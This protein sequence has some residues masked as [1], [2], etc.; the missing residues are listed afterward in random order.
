MAEHQ[1]QRGNSH[2]KHDQSFLH[3]TGN[4]GHPMTR[5]NYGQVYGMHHSQAAANMLA[6]GIQGMSMQD[7][8][9]PQGKGPLLTTSGPHYAGLAINAGFPAALWGANSHLMYPGGQAYPNS[10]HQ[11]SPGL[12]TPVSSQYLQHGYGQPHDNSPISQTWTPSHTTGEVPTLIT[13]RRDSVSSNENDAPGTPSYSTYPY[14][15][16]VTIINRSPNGIYTHSTP[17]PSQVMSQY[18]MPSIKTPEARSIS[19]ELH[20]LVSKE[21][22]IPPA[23]PAP[24]S[25]L[26]PL[27]RALENLRGETNVYIRGLHPDTTDDMLETWG[28]RFGDIRSS[29]SIIDHATGLCK[30]FGFVKYHNYEDAGNCIRGFHYLGYEVSFARESFYS[31][32]KTFADDDNTNLYVSNLPKAMN[33]HELASLFAPHKVCSARILR[34]KNGVGRGVGFARFE[35]RKTCTAVVTEFNNKAVKVGGDEYIINIR[36]A[37]SPEQKTLKQQVSSARAFRSQEY[38]AA[39]QQLSSLNEF[40]AALSPQSNPSATR[41]WSHSAMR[42]PLAPLPLN[43][44]IQSPT[45]KVQA[46]AMSDSKPCIA[47]SPDSPTSSE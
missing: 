27:D 18:G 36:Y 30:G 46:G 38:M 25:P 16:G 34:D 17:S 26:K 33:E 10:S 44:N 2:G 22:S 32:L 7:G 47:R 23:I 19:T 37:D 40:E 20:A 12:Y 43:N 35:D 9:Y 6:Q 31:K 13:P 11:H 45:S 39:T 24:S 21:P 41:S 4:Y 15:A 29:K 3:R 14:Q 28:R 1:G 8:G 5:G 42:P